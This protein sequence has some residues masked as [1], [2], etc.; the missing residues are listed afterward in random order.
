[1]NMISR[2][3]SLKAGLAAIAATAAVGVSREASAQPAVSG[4]SHLLHRS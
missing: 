2:R 3:D 1:M 4:A